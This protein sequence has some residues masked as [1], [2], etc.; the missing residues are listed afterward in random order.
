MGNLP[1][2]STRQATATLG[3][4]RFALMC[5]LLRRSVRDVRD[6]VGPV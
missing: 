3:L 2:E 6:P 1:G 4:L 5:N